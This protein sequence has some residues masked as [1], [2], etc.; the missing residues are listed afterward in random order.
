MKY[1]IRLLL[2]VVGYLC[3][4]VMAAG[5]ESAL[6]AD[7]VFAHYLYQKR[8][9]IYP[10]NRLTLI[11][12]GR[13]KFN[14]LFDDI[15]RA[16]HFI[17]LEYFN[18][19][20]DS[21]ARELF[22]DL[23]MRVKDSVRVRAMFDAFG[24]LSNNR[25][26]RREHL[27]MLNR[28][29]VEI[30]EFDPIRFP[31]VNHIFSRD[32]QKIVV[33]DDSIGYVG[34]MNVADYYIKGLPE[35]G[36]WRDMHLRIVGPAV[37]GLQKAFLYGWDKQTGQNLSD[38]CVDSRHLNGILSDSMSDGGA[39][40][41]VQRIPRVSPKSIR[42]AY[43]AAI[44]SASRHIQLINPYFTPSRRIRKAI[45]KA[46]ARGVKVEIMIPAKSDISF[47]PDAGFYFANGLRKA[48]AEVYLFEG[49]FHHSKVMMVDGR[50]CTVGSANL[51]S[52][53]LRY[54]YEINAFVFD[55]AIT[56]QLG[57]IFK[58][59]K[60][61]SVLMTDEWY[62]KDGLLKQCYRWFAHLFGFVL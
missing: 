49:G 54:D 30:V 60:E 41:I 52:R 22:A 2:L 42:E 12:S 21:I 46:V 40:A 35:I 17:H 47:T 59:D 25:P 57:Q 37:L 8:I 18:F 58:D 56:A 13:Q 27:T 24:N 29:G 19:R 10:G 44:N 36:P 9:P 20:N 14:L 39:V 53:S 4:P 62:R 33:I 55:R 15:R 43:V 6:P 50:Y 11:S 1:L 32:H 61:A 3:Y 26:L 16:R 38:S 34:G 7:S 28:R 31:Y 48:G 45:R 51:N 23:A 5:Q